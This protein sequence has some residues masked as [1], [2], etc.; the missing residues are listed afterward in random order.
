MFK[1]S[2]PKG[3]IFECFNHSGGHCWFDVGYGYAEDMNDAWA[4]EHLTDIEKV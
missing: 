1:I 3:A 2:I 4:K